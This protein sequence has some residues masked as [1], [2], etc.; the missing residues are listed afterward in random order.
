MPMV[1][2][3]KV[4]G[5]SGVLKEFLDVKGGLTRGAVPDPICS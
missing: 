2:A 4:L 3:R 5:E 1:K